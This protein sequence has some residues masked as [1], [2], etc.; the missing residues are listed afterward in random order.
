MNYDN[1]CVTETLPINTLSTLC[2]DDNYLGYL[3]EGAAKPNVH[4]SPSGASYSDIEDY[5]QRN[6]VNYQE[7][8]RSSQ[9]WSNYKFIAPGPILEHC[10]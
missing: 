9:T 4:V 5:L 10:H 8:S 3:H 1:L 6:S 2:P 7:T